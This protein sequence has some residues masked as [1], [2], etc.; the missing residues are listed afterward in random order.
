MNYNENLKTIIKYHRVISMTSICPLKG[1]N[2]VLQT[3][4]WS[5]HQESG[6]P[7]HC[8]QLNHQHLACCRC[9]VESEPLWAPTYFDLYILLLFWL[10]SPSAS[11]AKNL[12][13]M[14]KPQ[15][16][17]VWSQ[18]LEILQRRAWKLTPVFLPGESHEQWSLEGYSPQSCKESDTTEAT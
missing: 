3:Q 14:Q 7:V 9:Y 17:Q 6:L 10:G 5:Q 8:S 11:A 13:S 12:P 18:G 2:K 15:E 16:M 4:S 1:Q